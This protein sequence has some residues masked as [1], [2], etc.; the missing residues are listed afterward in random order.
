MLHVD[1]LTH[2]TCAPPF[3]KVCVWAWTVVPHSN[4]NL[5][6]YNNTLLVHPLGVSVNVICIAMQKGVNY[7][8][9]VILEGIYS[10][11][12]IY[13]YIYIYIYYSST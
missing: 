11:S 9:T 2:A 12:Y 5:L 13:I 1:N 3:S 6:I 10:Y 4:S 8:D 7:S